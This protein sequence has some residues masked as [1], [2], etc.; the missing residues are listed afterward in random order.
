V[1]L[2]TAAMLSLAVAGD[3]RAELRELW[4][5]YKQVYV[6]EDGRVID[7][8]N[9]SMTTSEGQSYALLRAL[10]MDDREAFDRVLGWTAANLQGGQMGALPAWKWGAGSDGWGVLDS[11]PASDADQIIIWSLLG[12]AKRW[13][14]PRYEEQARVLIAA[15]WVEEVEIIAGSP[16]VLPGPWARGSEVVRL[17]PSY[18]LPFVWR[19]FAAFDPA[20]PWERVIDTGYRLLADCRGASGLAMDWCYVDRE[21]GAVLPTQVEGHD[22][23]G[24]EAMRV[25]WALA[26]EV[27]WHRER[28]ARALLGPYQRLLAWHPEGTFVP[29]TVLADGSAGVDWEYPG[30]LGALLPAWSL[31]RPIGTQ[32]FQERRIDP[33]RAPHGWGDRDDYYGQNWIWFGL[34]LAQL[35]ELPA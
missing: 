7:F 2:G 20:H 13:G 10:W 5:A 24:F 28:R 32:R 30:M 16:V 12:A 11:A 3:P 14:E 1:A 4:Q 19:D 29:G 22:A 18:F 6:T 17:N 15:F 23:F 33:L 25:P 9:G 8:R 26:A 34:A 35:R 27:I 21:T 31:R